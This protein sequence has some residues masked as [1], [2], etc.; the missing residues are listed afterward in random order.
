M[1]NIIILGGGSSGLLTAAY[2]LKNLM[3]DTN[4]TL[5]EDKRQGPI[6]V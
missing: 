2:M 6:G 4:I 1:K 5:I 3:P